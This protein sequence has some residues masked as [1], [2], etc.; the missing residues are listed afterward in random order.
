MV[1]GGSAFWVLCYGLYYWISRIS[2]DSLSGVVLYLGYLFL[3]VLLDFLI[4]GKYMIY[5][6]DGTDRTP[7]GTI[8]FLASYW[9]VRRIY[10][11]IR[12]D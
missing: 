3:I 4:T 7:S 11:S 6:L 2:L 1:G 12:I 10:S 5:F 8:G 9:A